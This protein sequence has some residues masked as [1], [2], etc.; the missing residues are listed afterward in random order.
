MGHWPQVETRSKVLDELEFISFL[1][2]LTASTLACDTSGPHHGAD[3]QLL[4]SFK[5]LSA[6]TSL[7]ARIELK[8]KWHDHQIEGTVALDFEPVNFLFKMH[9]TGEVA[10]EADS[11]IMPLTQM[12]NKTPKKYT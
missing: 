10:T 11:N 8:P 9:A 5:K 3:H 1:S 6:L 2:F 7:I 12:S 4:L